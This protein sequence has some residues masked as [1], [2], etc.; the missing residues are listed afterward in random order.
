MR[1]VFISFRDKKLTINFEE[2][3]LKTINAG[4]LLQFKKENKLDMALITAKVIKNRSDEET[5]VL[6]KNLLS[7]KNNCLFGIFN[8]DDKI[9]ARISL[10]SYNSRNKSV[11]I[12]YILNANYQAKGIMSNA[13][14]FLVLQL[15]STGDFNKIYCQTASFNQ[16]SLALLNRCGF[17]KEGILRQHHE[18]DGKL[19]DDIIF[20]KLQSE[21]LR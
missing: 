5:R 19:Y 13:I 11:E 9:I 2:Y 10:Y 6:F 7:D 20:S 16:K 21:S 8:G 4:E 3:Y 18:Y 17:V 15:F 1:D 12:G 14:K